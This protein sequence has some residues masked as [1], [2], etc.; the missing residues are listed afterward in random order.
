MPAERYYLDKA[1]HLHTVEL[2]EGQEFHHLTHVMRA[3]AGETIEIMN[4]KGVLAQAIVQEISKRQAS[5]KIV[6][7]YTEKEPSL[8]VILAQ[9]LPRINR[10]DYLLEKCT[11]LGVSEIWLF[12]GQNSERKDL[13]DHQLDRLKNLTIAASK[14][15]GRLWLP[16]IH[17]K[18][19]LSAWKLLEHQSFFGDLS[20]T[21]EFLS[22]VLVKNPPSSPCVFFTGP[23]SGFTS[24][25]TELLLKL[26][27]KGVRLHEATLRTDTASIMALSIFMACSQIHSL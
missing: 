15:S 4:G 7:L 16:Q 8:R 2:L 24:Q 23:E 21:A 1:L 18:P 25:E 6:D 13:T 10:L 3:K 5:L 12:P 22:A 11:E 20:P 19:A 9:A 17:L 14:Q 26:G 27:V